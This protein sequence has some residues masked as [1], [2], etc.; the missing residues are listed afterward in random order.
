M[1]AV[2]NY[3]HFSAASI[4]RKLCAEYIQTISAGIVQQWFYLLKS[5][6]TNIHDEEHSLMNLFRK[7]MKGFVKISGSQSLIFFY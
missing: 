6:R 5:R 2:F 4:H 7:L 1:Y 3:K